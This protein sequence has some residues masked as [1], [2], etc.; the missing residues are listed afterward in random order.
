MTCQSLMND[1]GV[2]LNSCWT[3]QYTETLVEPDKQLYVQR[4]VCKV[5]CMQ[6]GLDACMSSNLCTVSGNMH[7]HVHVMY[8]NMHEA[9]SSKQGGNAGNRLLPSTTNATDAMT[10]S[11]S[12]SACRCIRMSTKQQATLQHWEQQQPFLEQ[13]RVNT[14]R[15]C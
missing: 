15:L 13:L 2:A 10:C 1:A 12:C 8:H 4:A 14:K 5:G 3:L 6:G 11:D 7:V 9:L